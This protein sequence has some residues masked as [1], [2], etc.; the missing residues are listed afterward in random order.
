MKHRKNE[1]RIKL[2]DQFINEFYKPNKSIIKMKNTPLPKNFINEEN[3]SIFQKMVLES[4]YNYVVDIHKSLKY[5]SF[6]EFNNNFIKIVIKDSYCQLKLDGA[7]L[8]LKQKSD[9]RVTKLDFSSSFEAIEALPILE[10]ALSK[11]SANIKRINTI[12]E[13]NIKV[14]EYVI[15]NNNTVTLTIPFIPDFIIN[16]YI[17]GVAIPNDVANYNVTSNVF[18]WTTSQYTLDVDDTITI[19]YY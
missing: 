12:D 10:A 8:L 4:L 19:V 17:N 14:Y 1:M 11:M 5:I 9:T 15:I 2:F 18:N 13:N 3:A 7:N 6:D 16:L